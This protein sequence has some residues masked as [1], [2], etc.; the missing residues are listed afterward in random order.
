MLKFFS[1]KQKY[2]TGQNT[3]TLFDEQSLGIIIDMGY[4][5]LDIPK[6]NKLYYGRL[7][8]EQDGMLIFINYDGLVLISVTVAGNKVRK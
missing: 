6:D 5:H 4:I 3:K 1:N 7:F 2:V 8:C